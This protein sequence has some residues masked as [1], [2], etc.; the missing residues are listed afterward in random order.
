M[1]ERRRV[2]VFV[3]G[4]VLGAAPM[5]VDVLLEG[6]IPSFRAR[7]EA[8]RRIA[9]FVLYPLV[10]SIPVTTAYAVLVHRVLDVHLIVRKAIQ[11]ALARS[12]VLVVAI[13]PFLGFVWYVYAHRNE[14]ITGLLSGGGPVVLVALTLLALSVLRLRRRALTAIDRRFFREQ[15]DSH[16]I[17]AGLVEKV[18]AVTNLEQLARLLK[19]EIDRALHLEGIAVLVADRSNDRFISLDQ[20]V[21]PLPASSALSV[22]VGGNAEPLQ[23]E[24]EDPGSP[25][26]RLPEQERQWV[27]EGAFRLIVP[28]IGSDASLVGLVALCQKRSE[29]PFTREDRLLLESIA[30][31][32]AMALENRLIRATTPSAEVASDT[33]A[34]INAATSADGG[35]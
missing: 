31:A 30:A 1:R 6:L 27:A 28:L 5:L 32:G 8:S 33:T 4:L 15:Y 25:L 3:T 12:T 20:Q 9:G 10:L 35:D 23:V 24:L 26:R 29:L 17:L 7:M 2:G 11:H 21:R 16:V 18:R 13:V 19:A 14:T 34:S 22:L